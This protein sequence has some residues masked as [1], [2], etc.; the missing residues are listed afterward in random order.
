MERLLITQALDLAFVCSINENEWIENDIEIMNY[1]PQ[2]LIG[3]MTEE[4]FFFMSKEH[5]I[6]S[7]EYELRD[8]EDIIVILHWDSNEECFV[9]H[10]KV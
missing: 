7:C 10:G 3:D 8:P 1:I 9:V 4:Y 6:I 2:E 5:L